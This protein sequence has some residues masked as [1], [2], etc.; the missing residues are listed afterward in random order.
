M[1]CLW[2]PVFVVLCE[3]VLSG[4]LDEHFSEHMRLTHN[5]TRNQE[6]LFATMMNGVKDRRESDEVPALVKPRRGLPRMAKQK[7]VPRDVDA[8]KAA[9][10]AVENDNF[11]QLL[12]NFSLAVTNRSQLGLVM[13]MQ[14]R[15]LNRLS[16]MIISTSSWIIFRLVSP[17]DL[18]WACEN[19]LITKSQLDLLIRARQGN[20]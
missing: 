9:K 18:N 13:L 1:N 3:E 17:T 15:L 10:Q 7:V 11:D 4:Q 16:R 6:F 14:E 8:R 20:F 19:E 5:V 12:D 2:L